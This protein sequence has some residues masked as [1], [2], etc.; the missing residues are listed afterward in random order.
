MVGRNQFSK[1]LALTSDAIHLAK[2]LEDPSLPS[3]TLVDDIVIMVTA[4]DA[5]RERISEQAKI[6]ESGVRPLQCEWC[7]LQFSCEESLT[8]HLRSVHNRGQLAITGPEGMRAEGAPSRAAANLEGQRLQDPQEMEEPPRAEVGDAGSNECVDAGKEQEATG[9]TSGA[10]TNSRVSGAHN[11]VA[12][13]WRKSYFM[14]PDCPKLLETKQRLNRHYAR[15]HMARDCLYTCHKCNRG[16]T[17]LTDR[18][19]H[20]RLCFSGED[21]GKVAVCRSCG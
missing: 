17:T 18:N 13:E 20:S 8:L 15:K 9:A 12:K 21:A 19:E 16:F 5:I 2:P 6:D 14:C 11:P 10:K 3:A 1:T 7:P 4:R